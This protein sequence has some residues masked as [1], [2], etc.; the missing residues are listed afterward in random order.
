MAPGAR[1]R[2]TSAAPPLPDDPPHLAQPVRGL[3]RCVRCGELTQRGVAV[4]SLDTDAWPP[5]PIVSCPAC[6]C[7]GER[8]ASR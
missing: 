4:G 7:P 8:E 5:Q 3:L 6:L 1:S 2:G